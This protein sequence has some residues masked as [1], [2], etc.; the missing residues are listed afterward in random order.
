MQTNNPQLNDQ[1]LSGP[2]KFSLGRFSSCMFCGHVPL[3]N[4]ISQIVTRAGCG[5]AR[6]S[7]YKSWVNKGYKF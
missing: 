3:K 2:H 1:E 6:N 4:N 5:Y 7:Q